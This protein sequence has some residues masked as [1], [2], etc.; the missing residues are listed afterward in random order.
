MDPKSEL[1]RLLEERSL[2]HPERRQRRL[3][4]IPGPVI[5]AALEKS[6]QHCGSPDPLTLTRDE[7]VALSLGW[8]PGELEQLLQFFESKGRSR[9]DIKLTPVRIIDRSPSG[10]K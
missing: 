6:W 5:T 1:V 10:A 2:S 3:R 7:Y 4:R 9:A 8:L